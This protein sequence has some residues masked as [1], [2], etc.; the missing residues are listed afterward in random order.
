MPATFTSIFL[1]C[2]TK[3]LLIRYTFPFIFTERLVI[4]NCRILFRYLQKFW[5]PCWRSW[6]RHCATNRQVAASIPDGVS[7]FFHWHNP[8]GCTMALG[9]TQPLTEMSTRNISWGAKGGRLLRA[10]NL[11]TFICRLSRNLGASTSW[12][13][14]GLSRPVMG[15]L[16]R[17]A[18]RFY[19][20]QCKNYA[21][22]LWYFVRFHKFYTLTLYGISYIAH[23][24]MVKWLKHV[25]CE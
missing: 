9:S 12:N 14:K 2:D 13:P 24:V 5:G 15:L 3:C 11:T 18:C 17:L 8:V 10:D 6:L 7:G 25:V 16:Y 22:I 23:L 1:L 19:N 4:Q 21:H 20:I